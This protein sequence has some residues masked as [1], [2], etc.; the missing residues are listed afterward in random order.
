MKITLKESYRVSRTAGNTFE[1]DV[2][3]QCLVREIKAG[4]SSVRFIVTDVNMVLKNREILLVITKETKNEYGD[5]AAQG[6]LIREHIT[7]NSL[8]SFDGKT[9]SDLSKIG[10][11]VN[12]TKE[13]PEG[14]KLTL[15]EFLGRPLSL[16]DN[17]L[18]ELDSIIL[19]IYS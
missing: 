14:F 12:G 13:I 6:G 19:S 8:I 3:G 9:R 4:T 1:R 7:K 17:L 18:T 10:N 2:L 15:N 11:D 5:W 16:I